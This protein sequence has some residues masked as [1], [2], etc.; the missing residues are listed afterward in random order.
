M[1]KKTRVR[2]NIELLQK[3]LSGRDIL[4]VYNVSRNSVA[5]IRQRSDDYNRG[6]DGLFMMKDWVA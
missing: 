2:Q 6:W 4:D 3:D 1:L 5:R